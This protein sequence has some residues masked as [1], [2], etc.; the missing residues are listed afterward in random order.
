ME[1]DYCQAGTEI[2]PPVST[3]AGNVGMAICYDMRFPELSIGLT[4]QGAEILTFPSA[5]TVPT[6]MAHWETLLRARAI[7]NQAYVIAAAQVGKHNEKRSSYGHTMVVDPWG[8]VV[9][10]CSNQ[11]DVVFAEID[12][13]LVHRCRKEMPLSNHRRHDVYGH[14]NIHSTDDINKQEV[15]QFGQYQLKSSQVFYKSALSIGFV[16]RKPVLPGHVLV[17]PVRPVA[18]FTDLTQAEVADL[19]RCTQ[20]I[21]EAI[22]S[23]FDGTSST[24]AIQD[25]PEAGQT[26][27][28]VHV[29]VLPR[30]KG[31]FQK[32]DDIYDKLENHD[33]SDA[34]QKWRSDEDMAQEAAKLRELF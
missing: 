11:V 34:T 16:N 31:D 1:S 30:K 18:R 12:L 32:N 15:Y 2:G 33:S 8:C 23:H 14:I 4:Q 9:A 21:A 13:E 22:K 24:I 3:P 10:E 29:H 26:V 27:T 28:H 25:G 6:G 20:I 5:F 19:F 7:E 17:S